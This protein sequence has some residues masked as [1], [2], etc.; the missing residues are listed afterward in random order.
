MTL[1]KRI[2][3]CTKCGDDIYFDPSK[4][5]T[6]GKW[7]PI[8]AITNEPHNCSNSDYNPRKTIGEEVMDLEERDRNRVKGSYN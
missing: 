8:D 6:N 7:I 5:S 2:K 3:V 1:L 4:K